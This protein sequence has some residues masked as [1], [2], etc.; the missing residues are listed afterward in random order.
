MEPGPIP[1]VNIAHNTTSRGYRGGDLDDDST[2]V[3]RPLDIAHNTL[4]QDF[5]QLGR[6]GFKDMFSGNAMTITGPSEPDIPDRPLTRQ[7]S[8]ALLSDLAAKGYWDNLLP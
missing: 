8:Y 6:R 1:G 3:S 7:E 5:A 2:P 4:P